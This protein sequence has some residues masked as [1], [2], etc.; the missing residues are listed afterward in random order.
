ML[1]SMVMHKFPVPVAHLEAELVMDM[2]RH[3]KDT[4]YLSGTMS[5][6][7]LAKFYPILTPY[8]PP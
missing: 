2:C 5:I 1:Q 8:T 6:E 7:L 4:C 3:V